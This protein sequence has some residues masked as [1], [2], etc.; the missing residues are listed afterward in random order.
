VLPN[1]FIDIFQLI[2][3]RKI[4]EAIQ[5]GEFDDLPGKGKPLH[6]SEDPLEPPHQRLAHTILKNAGIAPIEISLRRE[7]DQLKREYARAKSAEERSALM[8]EIRLMVLRIN[9]M[10]R[11]SVYAEATEALVDEYS[12]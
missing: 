7:L 11:T 1:D 3:E 2:A 10:H 8:R 12:P 9:L 5:R 4:A 6:L